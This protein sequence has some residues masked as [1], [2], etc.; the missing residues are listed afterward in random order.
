M[1]LKFLKT[2]GSNVMFAHFIFHLHSIEIKSDQISTEKV[3]LHF[4]AMPQINNSE[5]KI[6]K[7]ILHHN[8]SERITTFIFLLF[9][10]SVISNIILGDCLLCSKK[11]WQSDFFLKSQNF[12][13]RLLILI[14]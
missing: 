2:K 6:F 9:C 10:V 1:F 13:F 5:V 11:H 3:I 4:W 12:H 7:L 8:L 14:C